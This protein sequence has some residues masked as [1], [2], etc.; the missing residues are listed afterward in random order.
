MTSIEDFKVEQK[1]LEERVLNLIYPNTFIP[2]AECRPDTLYWGKGIDISEVSIS[3]IA[4]SG[5]VSFTGLLGS[6]ISKELHIEEGNAATYKPYLSL[7]RLSTGITREQIPQY[8]GELNYEML[9]LRIEW[10]NNMPPQLKNTRSADP[11]L[12]LERLIYLACLLAK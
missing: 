1:E 8:L 5:E 2:I 12:D 10:L 4:P 11:E 3:R 6:G 7:G 9:R